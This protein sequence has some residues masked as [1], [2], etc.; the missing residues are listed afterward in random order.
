MTIGPVTYISINLGPEVGE[1]VFLAGVR[2]V[3]AGRDGSRLYGRTLNQGESDSG[4]GI[5]IEPGETLEFP[6]GNIS[7][8]MADVDRIAELGPDGYAPVANTVWTWLAFPPRQQ[9]QTF[10][11]YLLAVARRLDVAHTHCTAALNFLDN[12]PDEKGFRAREAMF[13]ALGHAESMCVALSR[14]VHMVARARQTISAPIAVPAEVDTIEEA[15]LAIRNAFEHID[16]RAVGR[17]RNENS[18][19]A[20]SVFDQSD[21]FVSGVLRYT[22]YSLDIRAEV[23]PTLIAARRFIVEAATQAG[24]RKTFNESIEWPFTE[25]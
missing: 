4:E 2:V 15:V 7:V 5:L 21:F 3:P 10:V 23:M 16:E 18:V 13:N 20:M 14:A 25:E 9:D 8:T 1:N 11:N 24:L 22:G 17:A 19:D 12:P 6:A